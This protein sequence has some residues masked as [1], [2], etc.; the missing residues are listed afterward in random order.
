MSDLRAITESFREKFNNIKSEEE[1]IRLF[2]EMKPQLEELTQIFF[3]EN[4]NDSNIEEYNIN[5]IDELAEYITNTIQLYLRYHVKSELKRIYLLLSVES[6]PIIIL[7]ID[8]QDYAI[9]Y[10]EFKNGTDETNRDDHRECYYRNES[11]W[12]EFRSNC[13]CFNIVNVGKKLSDK[14]K[15]SFP[16]VTIDYV[17]SYDD[18]R[19]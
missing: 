16:F 10:Q 14:L 18:K 11:I 4:E 6:P 19:F 13:T 8:G 12:Y 15:E 3:S 2:A 1:A 17:D 9:D 7:T 5:W